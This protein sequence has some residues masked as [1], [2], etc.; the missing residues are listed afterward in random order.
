MGRAGVGRGHRSG[1]E[2]EG[3]LNFILWASI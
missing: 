1:S 2:V 3:F